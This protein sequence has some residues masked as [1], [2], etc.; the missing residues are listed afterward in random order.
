MA[1]KYIFN[2]HNNY[3][4]PELIRKKYVLI[5]FESSKIIIIHTGLQVS[6][7]FLFFT[8]RSST[9]GEITL[10]GLLVLVEGDLLAPLLGR[11]CWK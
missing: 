1:N 8:G 9:S 4:G 11:F 3:T 2:I 10:A 5:D 7:R 6:S